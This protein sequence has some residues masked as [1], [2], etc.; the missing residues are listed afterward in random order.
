MHPTVP[1]LLFSLRPVF[2]LSS[3]TL[4]YENP[5]SGVRTPPFDPPVHEIATFG[6]RTHLFGPP[7]HENRHFGVRTPI[8]G[9]L[10]H[11]IGLPG[12]RC[13]HFSYLCTANTENYDF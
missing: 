8:F 6:V 3:L 4:V 1:P 13:R 2:S 9:P 5:L 11:E 12:V 7:V 10:V